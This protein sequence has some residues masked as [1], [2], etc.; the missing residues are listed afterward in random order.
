MTTSVLEGRRILLVE[1]EM[2]ILMLAEDMLSEV[3][4]TVVTANTVGAALALIE[5]QSF[6]AVLLDVNLAGVESYP[7]AEAL[8]AQGT[9]FVFSTGY[10]QAGLRGDHQQAKVVA[11]PY[12]HQELVTAL[13]RVI[14]N[15]VS[16]RS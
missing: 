16:E 1:D 13:S 5:E 14:E 3:G 7:V 15:S 6:D 4:C 2:M 12:R 10:E 11:K 8:R 9:P